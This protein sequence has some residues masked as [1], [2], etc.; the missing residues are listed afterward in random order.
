MADFS[1]P[2]DAS[3]LIV[4]V[5]SGAYAFVNKIKPTQIKTLW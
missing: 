4:E 1:G 3:T 2:V 5:A